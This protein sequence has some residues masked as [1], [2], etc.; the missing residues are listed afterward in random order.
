MRTLLWPHPFQV[1]MDT[2]KIKG[3][4]GRADADCNIALISSIPLHAT[5]FQELTADLR[6]WLLS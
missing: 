5:S 1:S 2:T 6:G 4:H 3:T